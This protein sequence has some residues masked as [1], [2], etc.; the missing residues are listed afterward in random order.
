MLAKDDCTAKTT[1]DNTKP[2]DIA[3]TKKVSYRDDCL[4]Q[5][6]PAKRRSSVEQ[7]FAVLARKTEPVE[8]TVC[9]LS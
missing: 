8:P 9:T 5:I 7:P 4:V 1:L 3:V 6:T 2:L